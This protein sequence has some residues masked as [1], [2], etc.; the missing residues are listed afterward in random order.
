MQVLLDACVWID[1]IT[2]SNTDRFRRCQNVFSKAENGEVELWTSS[3][4]LAEVYIRKCDGDLTTM[5][6]DQDDMFESFFKSGLVKPILL[7]LQVAKISRRLSRKYPILR[8]PQDAVHVA[9]CIVANIDELHTFDVKDL[10]R[11]D[12]Q[13]LLRNGAPLKISEPPLPPPDLFDS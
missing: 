8:K 12:G 1:L 10:I 11:L 4:T 9:S 6:E 13:I 3:F 2:Q 7:D 5:P